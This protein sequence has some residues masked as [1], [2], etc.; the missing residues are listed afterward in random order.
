MGGGE[1]RVEEEVDFQG[2][3]ATN[4]KSKGRHERK[5]FWIKK[6]INFCFDYVILN[7]GGSYSTQVLTKMQ[8]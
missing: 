2:F 8:C 3:K 4:F 6:N 7:A 5:G 1:G